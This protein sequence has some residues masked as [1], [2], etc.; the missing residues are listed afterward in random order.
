MNQ[1]FRAWLTALATLPFL[2]LPLTAQA[3]YD[4]LMP[5][6][7]NQGTAGAGSVS[8]AEDASSQ[9]FNPALMGF[10]DSDS[11]HVSGGFTL[12]YSQFD[13]DT[14]SATN[15][16]G[17]PL[18]TRDVN[19]NQVLVNPFAYYVLPLDGLMPMGERIFLGLGITLP[20]QV[21]RD[22]DD[23]DPTRYASTSETITAVDINPSVAFKV[24]DRFSIGA[25]L[26]VQYIDTQYSSMIDMANV[27]DARCK[28][29]PNGQ[30][31][32][33]CD[34]L[35]SGIDGDVEI[36]SDA[37]DWSVGFNV[38]I[39]YEVIDDLMLGASFRYGVRHDLSGTAAS[40][41]S[42]TGNP[43]VDSIADSPFTSDFDAPDTYSLGATYRINADWRVMANF[44]YMTWSNLRNFDPHVSRGADDDLDHLP[45]YDTS[46]EDLDDA[47][48]IAVGAT[49]DV[50]PKL[51]L[52]AGF[53]FDQSPFSDSTR[54]IIHSETDRYEIGIGFGYQFNDRI[55]M[56]V[57]YTHAFM[58]DGDIDMA[59]DPIDGTTPGNEYTL[60]GS[61][62]Q[63]SDFIAVQV[64]GKLW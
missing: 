7:S 42:E 43:I 51:V 37:D 55:S 57:A 34:D 59:T 24:T 2:F 18:D 25:G 50:N 19:D 45:V 11:H 49:Y 62:R 48:R 20:Y 60:E 6:V 23:T 53:A 54:T 41:F 17:D 36:T 28:P 22:L 3:R 26:S 61:T 15:W 56:D 29:L 4:A 13:F 46:M 64:N 47:V 40:G 27:I 9:Y 52:R 14:D 44:D 58:T 39:A 12:E 10:L 35:P 32:E 38:G 30:L 63:S 21:Q 16:A 1:R 33:G 5:S 31:P 8:S